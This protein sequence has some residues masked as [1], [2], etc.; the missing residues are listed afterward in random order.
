VKRLISPDLVDVVWP[1]VA[2][3][4]AAAPLA[5]A[6]VGVLG[7]PANLD[8]WLLVVA[9]LL[10]STA[11]WL[12]IR[13]LRGFSRW[14]QRSQLP[15]RTLSDLFF[16]VLGLIIG[17]V[18]GHTIAEWW[19]RSPFTGP[20]G[21]LLLHVAVGV[22]QI[23]GLLSLKEGR[24]RRV[25]G[26]VVLQAGVF[27][28][29]GVLVVVVA[30][31]V[32]ARGTA[33]ATVVLAVLP[34]MIDWARYIGVHKPLG[35]LVSR[36]MDALDNV[37]D[38]RERDPL[39]GCWA[40]D[41]V[42]RR[43]RD[44]DMVLVWQLAYAATDP[45]IPGLA[46]FGERHGLVDVRDCADYFL[47]SAQTALDIVEEDVLPYLVDGHDRAVRRSFDAA[48]GA[49]CSFRSRVAH[50]QLRFDQAW[51]WSNAAAES[52]RAASM[53][54]Y[55][56]LALCELG[57]S[58]LLDSARPDLV[59]TILEPLNNDRSVSSLVRGHAADLLLLANAA[60]ASNPADLLAGRT[61]SRCIRWRC[62]QVSRELPPAVRRVWGAKDRLDIEIRVRYWQ[63][64][65]EEAL[66]TPDGT[67]WHDLPSDLDWLNDKAP[68]RLR[69][70]L[71]RLEGNPNVAPVP[72]GQL[73]QA[74]RLKAEGA[75]P[76][77]RD[78]GWQVLDQ[79]IE[80]RNLAEAEQANEFLARL[81][82]AS[83][84]RRGVLRYLL[85]MLGLYEEAR[86]WVVD[87]ETRRD[88]ESTM[89][90]EAVELLAA[91]ESHGEPAARTVFRLAE[92][93]RSRALLDVVAEHAAPVVPAHLTALVEA[94]RQALADYRGAR[95]TTGTAARGHREE[96]RAHT[97]L[98]AVWQR[99]A[100]SGQDG[101]EYL[102]ARRGRPVDLDDVRHALRAAASDSPNRWV[103]FE[104]CKL[105]ND[106]VVLVV[107]D[108]Y[109]EPVVVT[110]P[111]GQR[112]DE[113]VRWGLPDPEEGLTEE[114]WE[115]ALAPLVAPI[116][117]HS[118]EGDLV[119]LSPH[120]NLHYVP[121]HAIPVE[122]V[123]LA[124]RNPVCYN[125]SASVLTHCLGRKSEPSGRSLVFADSDAAKPL[126]FSR[127]E[128][129]TVARLATG[130]VAV[131]VGESATRGAL[132]E[133]L[134]GDGLDIVHLACHASFRPDAPLESGVTLAGDD[135]WTVR[136][137][138]ALR[139]RADLVSLSAC[140]TAL[141]RLRG[142][143]QHIGLTNALLHAGARS[144]LVTLWRVNDLATC[145][146]ME[147]F[148]KEMRAGL[149]KA[150]AL[151]A[152]QMVVRNVTAAEVITYCENLRSTA[153]DDDSMIA[154]GIA[155]I[156]VAAGDLARAA[157]DYEQV[158][159]NFVLGADDRAELIACARSW[160]SQ[161]VTA[162]P[163]DYNRTPYR[164]PYFWAPFTLVGDWR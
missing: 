24:L 56:A 20:L 138:L 45:G 114:E 155:S 125:P 22:V 82:H 130:Q 18:W 35:R 38:P 100:D 144:V 74:E 76:E 75:Y 4:V 122:G 67:R 61:A 25:L 54:N 26:L 102:N 19:M 14:H 3:A 112:L 65:V 93:A 145:L 161:A 83:G 133:Q 163:P 48:H 5:V 142:N 135:V 120:R 57:V 62:W 95:A 33:V 107:R 51:S 7:A 52:Y 152:A 8:H 44:P 46:E 90:D 36:S 72:L 143:D 28:T 149:S 60:G 118:A 128:A 123:P 53:N 27:L 50:Q 12:Q 16:I 29:S 154:R 23:V 15:L 1:R 89:F 40:C 86:L 43:R 78:L 79:A 110:V 124:V 150:H 162:D 42:A 136:D 30:L 116:G 13:D 70:G 37:V 39:L 103:L 77:A 71:R 117:Q 134:T 105:D 106:I 85:Q 64:S 49:L 6:T 158:T 11:S 59:R 69:R 94:E 47:D 92:Q 17:L 131:R 66:R 126:A 104:F 141:S 101:V 91:G 41:S 160:R 140:V 2:Y 129:R 113:A 153:G 80:H 139:L 98:L 108:D 9:G 58:V 147:A 121:L 32:P 81:H 156:R 164:E 73:A 137:I 63:S 87:E 127:Q 21:G 68:R 84:D 115:R 132:V 109:P 157:D 10:F 148:Y 146:L 99:L 111:R 97:E 151:Q 159:Q 88:V 31:A 119:L 55:A 34:V 96:M